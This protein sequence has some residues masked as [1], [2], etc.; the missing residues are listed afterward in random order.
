MSK[1]IFLTDLNTDPESF[2]KISSFYK[3]CHGFEG[4]RIIFDFSNVKWIDAHL[5]AP[6]MLV[7]EKI[8]QKGNFVD[9]VN[10]IPRV[11]DILRRN[12]F[13]STN[14]LNNRGTVIPLSSFKVDEGVSYSQ[15]IRSELD[16]LKL[17]KMTD[18]LRL[19]IYEGLDEVFMNSSIHAGS[20]MPIFACGQ[21][22]PKYERIDFSITDGGIGIN[23]AYS[24]AF[25]SSISAVEAIDWAMADGNTTRQG[26]IP[27]GL[28]LKILRSFIH[29]NSGRF[30]VV[31]R[32]GYWMEQNGRVQRVYMKH[33]FPGTVVTIEV[34]TADQNNYDLKAPDPQNLW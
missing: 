19:K 29:L 2:D 24:K 25:G 32:N 20:E 31:S 27:G 13:F 26:D 6:M 34:N 9:F 7:I 30:I 8:R 3:V 17:P 12:G 15:F 5:S 14:N 1:S 28:G 10:A 4:E 33:E 11:E 22:F 18:P 16:R 23:G 21:F